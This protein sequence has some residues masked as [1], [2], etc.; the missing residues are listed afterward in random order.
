MQENLCDTIGSYLLVTIN[1]STLLWKGLYLFCLYFQEQGKKKLDD[2]F[3]RVKRDRIIKKAKVVQ[4]GPLKNECVA[5]MGI[6]NAKRLFKSGIKPKRARI[7]MDVN[8]A[9][10]IMNFSS[11]REFMDK[12]LGLD[13]KQELDKRHF[14]QTIAIM[15]QKEKERNSEVCVF[16]TVCVETYA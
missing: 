9:L 14:K 10:G 8:K 4:E 7:K 6:S 5:V 15:T 2:L 1:Y 13:P 12:S 11:T 16:I 3:T